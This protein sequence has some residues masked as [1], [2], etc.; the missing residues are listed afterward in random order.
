MVLGLAVGSLDVIWPSEGV[1][2]AMDGPLFLHEDLRDGTLGLRLDSVPQLTQDAGLIYPV[3]INEDSDNDFNN[4]LEGRLEGTDY[5]DLTL[6]TPF[7]TTCALS[8]STSCA[9][10]VHVLP[11]S[12]VD[13]ASFRALVA[14]LRH[15]DQYHHFVSHR[16]TPSMPGWYKPGVKTGLRGR[17][18]IISLFVTLPVVFSRGY[19]KGAAAC[20]AGSR[21]SRL[22]SG[23]ES[24]HANRICLKVNRAAHDYLFG[25]HHTVRGSFKLTTVFLWIRCDKLLQTRPVWHQDG[26]YEADLG[27]HS[28]CLLLASIDRRISPANTALVANLYIN[29]LPRCDLSPRTAPSSTP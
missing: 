28:L 12:E 19:Q 15:T 14:S 29:H 23:V 11:M 18:G 3:E 27:F 13:L 17:F 24:S 20:T 4:H 1:D 26:S 25:L 22:P 2:I 9:L 5:L 21:C 8:S 16:C 7:D 6:P 10:I